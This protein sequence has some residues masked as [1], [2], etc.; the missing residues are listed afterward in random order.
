M[1]H[2]EER[3]GALNGIGDGMEERNGVGDGMERSGVP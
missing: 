3:S 1:D 2:I